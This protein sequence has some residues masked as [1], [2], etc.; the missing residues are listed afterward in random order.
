MRIGLAFAVGAACCFGA[1]A[2]LAA[3]LPSPIVPPT[4]VPPPLLN[5][6]GVYVG[7]QIGGIWD[8]TG[9]FSTSPCP[10]TSAATTISGVQGGGRIG[11]NYQIGQ[12]VFGLETSF[13]G[14]SVHGN[15]T[16]ADGTDQLTSRV[17]VYGTGTARLGFV[18]DRAL[19]YGKGGAAWTHS[20]HGDFDSL[21]PEAFST[22]YWRLGWALGAGIE[23]AIT[24]NWSVNLEYT[25]IDTGLQPTAFVAAS[26]DTFFATMH[27]RIN[28]A[29]VGVNYKF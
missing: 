27:Q 7:A 25:Y 29:T 24:P 23:Y 21:I 28:S 14:T 16:A 6:T 13:N 10:C 20:S 18:V 26:G 5:W 19:I 4:F 17:D 1:N 3:D 2:A 11:Y 22:S 15:Y 8:A 12:A 9:G